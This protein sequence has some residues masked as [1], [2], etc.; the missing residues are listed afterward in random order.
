[1][2]ESAAEIRQQMVGTLGSGHLTTKLGP[3]HFAVFYLNINIT[4]NNLQMCQ[5]CK[6]CLTMV[7]FK[8]APD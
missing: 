8:K 1:M 3:D 2:L 6:P 5:T 4:T 7:T